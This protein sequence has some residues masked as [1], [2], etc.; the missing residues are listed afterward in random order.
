MTDLLAKKSLGQHWLTDHSALLAMVKAGQVNPGDVVLEIGPGYG[1][2]TDELLKA[3]AEIIA[4]E[5]D[6][7]LVKNLKTKYKDFPSTQIWIKE[8]D[9]RTYDFGTNLG[10]YKIV[11]NIPYYITANLMRIL[12]DTP[13]KPEIAAL[14]V[15]KEVAERIG[16]EPGKMSALGVIMQFY[17]EVSLGVVVPAKLFDP[18]PKVDSQILI[19][20]RRDNPLFPDVDPKVFF[21]VVKA[22]FSARR[23]TLLNSLA[24]GLR[25]GKEQIELD[26]AAAGISPSL[27]A[28]NLSLDDWH[29]LYLTFA[30]ANLI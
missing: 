15:Q 11:S 29:K 24:G 16:A 28:Q 4:L 21:R 19:L 12:S 2:L 20:K 13:N 9:I 18:V 26:L 10:V 23:K 8:G 3:K 30:K 25:L 6:P 27:R 7:E 14:L 5:Y 22:G 1:N 17:Y